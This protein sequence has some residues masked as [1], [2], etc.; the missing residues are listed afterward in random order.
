MKC[1]DYVF[2]LTSGQLAESPTR[3]QWAARWHRVVCR[4]CRAFTR[5]DAVLTEVLQRHK[6]GQTPG[7]P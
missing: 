5:N 7:K 3:E 4:H 1:Q 6:Q 2:R